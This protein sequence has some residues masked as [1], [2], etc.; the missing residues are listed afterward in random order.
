[1]F[2]IFIG[3]AS[4]C[5][6]PI[7]QNGKQAAYSWEVVGPTGERHPLHSTTSSKVSVTLELLDEAADVVDWMEKQAEERAR[8]ADHTPLPELSVPVKA[9]PEDLED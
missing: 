5:V 6:Y 9:N 1:M 8:L 3:N 7:P 4:Y 2:M